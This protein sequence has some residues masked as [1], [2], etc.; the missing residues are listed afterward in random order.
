MFL[1]GLLGFWGVFFAAVFALPHLP[2]VAWCPQ[3]TDM[4]VPK[5]FLCSSVV[6][7]NFAVVV[8]GML[9]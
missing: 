5:L 4:D 8:S 7:F 6:I 3:A 2:V 1:S 9:N